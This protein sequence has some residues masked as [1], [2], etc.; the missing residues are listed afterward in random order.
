VRVLVTGAAGFLGSHVVDRLLADGHQVAGVDDLSTGRLDRLAN[1]R[2]TRGLALTRASVL[3]EGLGELVR[4]AA[5]EVVVHLAEGRGEALDEVRVNVLG[6]AAVLAAAAA[7][8]ARK[9]V[10]GSDAAVYGRPRAQPVSERAGLAPRSAYGASRAA[11]ELLLGPAPVATTSL[12]LGRLYGPR[13]E[14]GAVAAF[15][16]A[17]AGGGA[18]TVFGDGTTVRDWLYV[19][20][21]VD[22]VLRAAGERADGRRLN[23]GSG[24]GVS[25]AALHEAV[26][27]VAGRPGLVPERAPAIPGELPSLVLEVGAARRALGWEPF[28]PLE[29][30][31]AATLEAARSQA[32]RRP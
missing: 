26:C 24:R 21:A 16:R 5:P 9:V 4:R 20:D 18:G 6:T 25:V 32:A 3:D 8:G 23:V 31:L 7:A 27:A 17:L 15:C 30:G 10:V 2:A 29:K 12:V 19:D 22:A 1:A 13:Q 11:A 14:R 28:T